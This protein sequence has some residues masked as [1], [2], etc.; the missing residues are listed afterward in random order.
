M[1]RILLVDDHAILR[2]GLRALL[3]YYPEVEVVGE[4]ADGAEAIEAVSRLKPDV[5]LMDIAMPVMS[6][7]E[8]T[9]RICAE[10]PDSRVI[11]LTQY[12][13]QPYV[14]PLLRAGAA[15]YVLKRALG[16]DL[17][18]AIRAVARGESFL[19]SSVA[20]TVLEHLRQPE[21]AA[22]EEAQTLTAREM[23][24]LRRVARGDTSRQIALDLDLSIKTVEWHRGNLMHKLGA[25]SVAEA[26]RIAF[27]KGLLE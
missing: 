15:G 19:Y 4:A 6:G 7:L 5:V 25:R 20:A 17:M 9:R 27:Q 14:M 12:E 2:E 22:A 13:D 26:V 10:H 21:P 18:N 1:I 24:V 16:A 23:E 3:S 8:A 11:I